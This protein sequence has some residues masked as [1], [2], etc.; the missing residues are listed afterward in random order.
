M[1]YSEPHT[2]VATI[3]SGDLTETLL[4]HRSQPTS[5][6]KI[7]ARTGSRIQSKVGNRRIGWRELSLGQ[8]GKW[9]DETL[10]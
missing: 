1:V 5:S 7:Q 4:F 10:S 3:L 9:S 6:A 2:D 8:I